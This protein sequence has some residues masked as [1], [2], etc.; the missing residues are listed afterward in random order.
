[1]V[2]RAARDLKAGDEVT[3][4]YYD[5]GMPL[6]ERSSLAQRKER[7]AELWAMPSSRTMS[8]ALRRVMRLEATYADTLE[9]RACNGVKP[10]LARAYRTLVIFCHAEASDNFDFTYYV[11][12]IIGT[13]MDGLKAAGMVITDQSMFGRVQSDSELPVDTS[14]SPYQPQICAPMAI[15]LASILD[16]AGQKERA[17]KWLKVAI[18]IADLGRGGGKSLF[19]EV[20]KCMLPPMPI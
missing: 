17:A 16:A 7:R 12:G 19:R 1:M 9:R 8:E 3:L 20:Y 15:R 2:V 18:W 14:K 11:P 10:A 13:I 6:Q 4:G 5:G